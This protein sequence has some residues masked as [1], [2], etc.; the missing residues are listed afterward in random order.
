[1]ISN[2]HTLPEVPPKDIKELMEVVYGALCYGCLVKTRCMKLD[3][4]QLTTK[5]RCEDFIISYRN[6][7]EE[8]RKVVYMHL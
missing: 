4:T 8:Y 6:L 2:N 1:M 3:V 5:R 7:P